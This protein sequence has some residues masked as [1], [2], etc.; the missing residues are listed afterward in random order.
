MSEKRT[1]SAFLLMR[2]AIGSVTRRCIR[3]GAITN[4]KKRMDEMQAQLEKLM[5]INESN[6][7][8]IDGLRYTKQQQEEEIKQLRDKR[9]K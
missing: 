1:A 4:T 7:C 9:Q 3:V 8:Q 5:Q 6:K 2:Y